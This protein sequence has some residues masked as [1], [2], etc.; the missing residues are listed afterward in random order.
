MERL[1]KRYLMVILVF[2]MLLA[3]GFSVTAL[4]A[5]ASDEKEVVVEADEQLLHRGGLSNV[6]FKGKG[7][8]QATSGWES[9]L[10]ARMVNALSNLQTTLDISDL[11]IATSYNE[12]IWNL[13]SEVINENPALFFYSGGIGWSYSPSSSE[14]KTLRFQLASKYALDSEGLVPNVNKI[15]TDRNAFQKGLDRA[16]SVVDPAM[17]NVEKVLAVHDWLVRECDYD[18]ANYLNK[19]IPDESYTAYGVFVNGK[20]VCQGY[21]LAFS[22]ILQ[23]LGISSYIVSSPAMNHAWNMVYVD[24]AWF[25]VDATWD[26]P[27]FTWGINND[28]A[29][30]GY[31]THTYFMLSDDEILNREHYGWQDTSTPT[32]AVSGRYNNY[33]FYSKA[34]A[35]NYYNGFW[36]YASGRKIYKSKINGNAQECYTSLYS[37]LYMHSIGNRAYFLTSENLGTIYSVDMNEL[38]SGKVV[39]LS[40]L[41]AGE[42]AKSGNYEI[43]EFG[44]KGGNFV[45]VSYNASKGDFKRTVVEAPKL[46]LTG[47]CYLFQDYGIDVG[48]AYEA[49]NGQKVTF[50]WS[51]YNLDTRQWTNITDWYDGNWATWKPA[52]GNYW[53]HVEAKTDTGLKDEYTICFAVTKDYNT[54]TAY[55]NLDGFCYIYQNDR[56]DFGTAYSSS[57][58]NVEFR[59]LAYNLDT[60]VWETMSGWYPGNW[61]SWRPKKGNYWVHVEARTASGL[62]QE[63][64]MCFSAERNYSSLNLNGICYIFDGDGIRIGVDYDSVDPNTTFQWLS[65]NLDTEVWEQITDWY[66]GNWAIWKP[67]KGNYLLQARARTSDGTTESYT[68]CF[69]SDKS[70]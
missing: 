24:G 26:D 36:Y 59:W 55:L 56:I 35:M 28:Y 7:T 42:K 16:L 66:G 58:S 61:I 45:I 23:Q 68:I 54:T 20:A 12:R 27:V 50:K 69:Y 1:R 8:Y 3:G 70:Y 52:K 33:C 47:I 34:A 9:V 2:A 46:D 38:Q 14:I 10:K 25:H 21:S 67:R 4:A 19:T 39:N 18:Y 30:E 29:D 40:K 5:E 6:Y 22:T 60:D 48:V 11:H 63:N 17:N 49:S 51:A 62:K 53:L 37:I 15:N 31:V 65:Y 32:A 57:E 43:T 64:T 41:D 13:Y 44:M